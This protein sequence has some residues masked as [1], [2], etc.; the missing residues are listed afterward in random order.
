[1][2]ACCGE[3]VRSVK[4]AA[5]SPLFIL[6]LFSGVWP[7]D[8]RTAATASRELSQ[9]RNPN[10][11]LLGLGWRIVEGDAGALEKVAANLDAA[12]HSGVQ[13][14]GALSIT[15][16]SSADPSGARALGKILAGSYGATLEV[17]V[18]IA[19]RSIH[20][21]ESLPS[22]HRLLDSNNE[23]V[24][25]EAVGGFSLFLLGAAPLNDRNQLTEFD[26]SRNPATRK[27]LSA[28]E[29]RHIHFG[30]YNAAADEAE[31]IHWWKVWFKRQPAA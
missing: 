13:S 25:Q 1:M 3:Y 17:P 15:S 18:S 14:I 26:R 31:I 5:A 10:L 23:D 16:Y 28:G 9:S 20:S 21:R 11:R 30:P 8:S 4:H 12:M 7:R 22:L 24:R 27:S 2:N 19:I 6:R 29:E